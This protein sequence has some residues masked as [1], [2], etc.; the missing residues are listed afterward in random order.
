M[1]LKG[2]L[3]WFGDEAVAVTDGADAGAVGAIEE[4]PAPGDACN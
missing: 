2:N 3:S 4:A 1:L